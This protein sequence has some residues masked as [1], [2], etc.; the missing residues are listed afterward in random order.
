[1]KVALVNPPLVGSINDALSSIPSQPV[2]LLSIAALLRQG[3]LEVDVIDCFA[4][5]PC[6]YRETGVLA[7][8]GLW[9]DALARRIPGD[10]GLV[11]ISC[12]SGLDQS[13][14]KAIVG[15]VRAACGA[16][17]VVGGAHATVSPRE[18][19]EAG[20]DYVVRGDGENA[21]LALARA[22]EGGGFAPRATGLLGRGEPGPVEVATEDPEALPFP[23]YD[24]VDLHPYWDC[25]DAHGPFIGPYV[26]VFT[27]RGC[28]YSCRF[29]ASAAVCLRRWRPMSA[30]RAVDLLESL[31]GTYE[32]ADFHIQD[33]MFS[34]RRERVLEF[35]REIV[36]RSLPVTWCL[37]TGIRPEHLEPE[38][39]DVMAAAGLR[40][41]H[42]APESGSP[43]VL[44][45]MG[46]KI[47]MDG[48]R[49]FVSRARALGVRSAASFIVGYPGET[50]DDRALTRDFALDLVRRGLDEFAAFVFCPVPGSDAWGLLDVPGCERI[51][52][53]P[54][55]RADW[56]AL[57]SFRRRLI[58]AAVWT[59]VAGDPAAVLR[60]AANV[61]SGR[62]E[63][64]AEMAARRWAK[65]AMRAAT[66]RLRGLAHQGAVRR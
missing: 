31:H 62:F 35:S 47:D 12:N 9:G 6:D 59:K 1:M 2:G 28:P 48:M 49:A 39:L 22:L 41:F 5:A 25:G 44:E 7:V 51:T 65:L 3:G 40:Y 58:A 11:G 20:A 60:H 32:V 34:V 37:A 19:F 56:P 61:A 4:E 17:I 52:S 18:M 10:A 43:R 16:K 8:Q 55:W 24:L 64:K 54:S 23:A 66:A 63:I 26:D 50:D 27:S 14:M 57:A 36:R 46:K 15:R 45:L 13:A 29:C 33:A 38:D 21:M 53:S 30:V 42:M